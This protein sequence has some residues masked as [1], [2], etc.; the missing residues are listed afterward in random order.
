M[1]H[2]SEARLNG[3]LDGELGGTERARV[4]AHLGSCAACRARLSVL[5]DLFDDLA[6]VTDTAPGRDLAGPVVHAI[7]VRRRESR[8]IAGLAGVQVLLGAVVAIAGLM[9]SGGVELLAEVQRGILAWSQILY[10]DAEL[11]GRDFVEGLTEASQALAELVMQG[12]RVPASG[13]PGWLEW[14]PV[15]GLV[16]ALWL[17]GNGVLLGGSWPRRSH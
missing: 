13:L 17:L 8:L 16:L 2:L 6:R 15:L 10:L 3:Y 4:E 1:G 14:G 7:R 9:M 12:L 11:A 5:E